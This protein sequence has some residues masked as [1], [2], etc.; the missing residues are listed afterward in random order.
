M[1]NYNAA[2]KALSDPSRLRIMEQISE[3]PLTV[4]QLTDLLPIS[5]PAVSQHLDVLRRAELVAFEPRGASNVY[6]IDPRG[7]GAMRA[8]LDRHWDSALSNYSRLLDEGE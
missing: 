5:Q 8:W 1:T 2:F 3:K 6:R 4:R 7:L